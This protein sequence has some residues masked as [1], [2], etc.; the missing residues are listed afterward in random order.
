MW[1]LS[2]WIILRG[3]A[4][5][6]WRRHCRIYCHSLH[7]QCSVYR[8]ATLC[9]H[10][11]SVQNNNQ[12]HIKK[13]IRKRETTNRPKNRNTLVW[14]F[15]LNVLVL[16]HRGDP[17]DPGRP[18]VVSR[19]AASR[20][21]DHQR[22]AGAEDGSSLFHRSTLPRQPRVPLPEGKSLLWGFNLAVFCLFWKFLRHVSCFA[23]H[24]LSFPSLFS[25][26]YS[27]FV[28]LKF[29]NSY[30]LCCLTFGLFSFIWS[31]LAFVLS[32]CPRNNFT[33]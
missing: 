21:H 1:G 7:I 17:A 2:C 15:T 10:R 13:N 23:L 14:N 11:A 22:H 33:M 27:L 16:F 4:Q 26:G 19:R 12:T 24:F 9:S 25:Q 30:Q 6:H 18:L 32:T 20:L 5:S 8:G 3:K 29:L 28:I 31:K